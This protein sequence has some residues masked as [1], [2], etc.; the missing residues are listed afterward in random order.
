[1]TGIRGG[2]RSELGGPALRLLPTFRHQADVHLWGM[3]RGVRVTLRIVTMAAIK[4]RCL[5]S[6]VWWQG[7]KVGSRIAMVRSVD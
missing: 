4:W 5:L 7:A 6:A 3:D 2:G 1:M